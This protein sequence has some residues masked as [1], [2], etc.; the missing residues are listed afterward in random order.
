MF[1]K[2]INKEIKVIVKNLMKDILNKINLD[3]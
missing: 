3:W 2:K 1:L